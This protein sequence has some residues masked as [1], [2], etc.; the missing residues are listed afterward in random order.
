MKSIWFFESGV[1]LEHESPLGAAFLPRHPGHRRSGREWAT[2]GLRMAGVVLMLAWW[3]PAQALDPEQ[4]ERLAL[5]NDPELAALDARKS[6]VVELRYFGG[7][8]VDETAD[9]L[10]VS[11]ETVMRDW[12]MA[13]LWLLRELDGRR[14]G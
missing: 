10:S 12:Q 14:D 11:P 1:P 3:L 2:Y 9:A 13:K 6:Q 5:A 4:A 8:S 7:L